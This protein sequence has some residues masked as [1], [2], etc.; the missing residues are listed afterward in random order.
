MLTH[1]QLVETRVPLEDVTPVRF[2]SCQSMATAFFDLLSSGGGDGAALLRRMLSRYTRCFMSHN[3]LESYERPV[4]G[5]LLGPATSPERYELIKALHGPRHPVIVEEDA[6][7]VWEARDRQSGRLVAVKSF[8]S[9]AHDSRHPLDEA[10]ILWQ[11]AGYDGSQA[12]SLPLIPS[13]HPGQAHCLTIFDSLVKQLLLA[14][15]YLHDGLSHDAIAHASITLDNVFLRDRDTQDELKQDKPTDSPF[16]K[17]GGF[18][19]GALVD[20]GDSGPPELRVWGLPPSQVVTLASLDP[21]ATWPSLFSEATVHPYTRPP[22][23]ELLEHE[24]LKGVE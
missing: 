24:W 3:L 7:A 22:A 10:A 8:R 17:L 16:L 9:L 15:D 5:L 12:G 2:I 18:N 20:E 4:A 6:P 13:A 1:T 23:K 21:E 11:V 14:V 19:S